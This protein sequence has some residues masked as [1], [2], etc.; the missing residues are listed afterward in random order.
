MNQLSEKL[1]ED[2]FEK[3][4][5]KTLGKNLTTGDMAKRITNCA[6]I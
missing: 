1:I 6:F 5:E 4:T 3:L 2:L